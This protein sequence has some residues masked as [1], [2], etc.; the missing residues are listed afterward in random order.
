[1]YRPHGAQRLAEQRRARPKV[2]KLVADRELRVFVE[3]KLMR[4]WSPE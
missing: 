1:M 2:G 3:D 4:R